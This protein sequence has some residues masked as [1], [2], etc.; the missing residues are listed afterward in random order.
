[1]VGRVGDFH[2][3]ADVFTMSPFVGEGL[4]LVDMLLKLHRIKRTSK[5]VLFGAGIEVQKADVAGLHRVVGV[6]KS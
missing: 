5:H 2:G 6:N 4:V 1:M 3:T